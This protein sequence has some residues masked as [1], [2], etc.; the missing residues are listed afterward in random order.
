MLW[1]AMQGLSDPLFRRKTGVKRTTFLVMVEELKA[2]EAQARAKD[3]RGKESKFSPEDRVLILLKYYREYPTQFSMGIELGVDETT[4]GRII[5]KTE[6][7]LM[8]SKRFRLPGKKSLQ[9]ANHEIEVVIVDATESPVERPK[10][11][12]ATT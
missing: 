2:A 9:P 3:R 8:K 10:K 1:N 6:T 7:M 4:V 12:A 11:K 5:R